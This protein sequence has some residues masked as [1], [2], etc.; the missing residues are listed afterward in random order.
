MQVMN[1][2]A[3]IRPAVGDEA[4][5]TP[6]DTLLDGNGMGGTQKI[7]QQPVLCPRKAVQ[8]AQVGCGHDEHMDRRLGADVPESIGI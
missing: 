6:I 8:A 1:T 5:A 4:V 7:G 2:L 3:S